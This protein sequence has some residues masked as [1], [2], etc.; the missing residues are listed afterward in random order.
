MMQNI[1]RARS[2]ISVPLFSS[3]QVIGAI[4]LTNMKGAD[5]ITEGGKNIIKAFASH[6][7]PAIENAR[8][9]EKSDSQIKELA[10]LNR[11]LKK[12][13]GKLEELLA[14]KSEFLHITSHQLRTPLTAIRG[15]ISMWLDGDFDN[16][17]PE[18]KNEMLRRIYVSTERLNNVTNDMLDALELE[19][20]ALTITFKKI[21]IVEMIK[22]TI[23]TLQPNYDKKGLY[24]RFG[25]IDKNVPEVDAEPNYMGQ[26]FMNLIDNACKYTRTGGVEIDVKQNKEFVE[27]YIKDT[28]IGISEKDQGRIFEKF[29]RGENAMA[30]NASGSGLGLFIVKKILD[31]HNGEIEVKSEGKDKGAVFKISLLI[32]QG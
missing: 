6:V 14:M 30:E 7:G 21:N 23:A 28:G 20:G 19:G 22:D 8:L 31:E 16:L 18:K 27:V 15:M 12:S 1:L 25:H 26:V 5:E 24:L 11:N 4:I 10:K 32:D 13:H 9:Y 29:T 3:G 2:F 17:P